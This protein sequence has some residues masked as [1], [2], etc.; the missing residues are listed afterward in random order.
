MT[1]YLGVSFFSITF[2]KTFLISTWSSRQWI[3]TRPAF[4]QSQ[5]C[6]HKRRKVLA[7]YF[8]WLDLL[9]WLFPWPRIHLVP[10]PIY[11]HCYKFLFQESDGL[12]IIVACTVSGP[13]FNSPVKH[14][15]RTW[16]T[17]RSLR[18]M[19]WAEIKNSYY[20]TQCTSAAPHCVHISTCNTEHKAT[21]KCSSCFCFVIWGPHW[22]ALHSQHW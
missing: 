2:A 9:S 5:K 22:C 20:N 16:Q 18:F 19:R 1:V 8:G 4:S 14:L 7:W 21:K 6:L 13:F 12:G 3:E 10:I 17:P 15:K 11:K